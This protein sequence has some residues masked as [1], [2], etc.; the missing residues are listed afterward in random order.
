MAVTPEVSSALPARVPRTGPRHTGTESLSKGP[1]WKQ[2][3]LQPAFCLFNKLEYS[4]DDKARMIEP[5]GD[6]GLTTA[7]DAGR[8][9]Q[10]RQNRGHLLSRP[11]SGQVEIVASG[12]SGWV[13]LKSGPVDERATE[14]TA[15]VMADV[16]PDLLAVVEVESRLALKHFSDALLSAVG[17]TPLRSCH[18]D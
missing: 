15:K 1:V 13:E 4:G 18:A 5:L 10:L 6:L 11:A 14:Y 8:F 7:D 2:G 3:S 16:N 12:R 17:A 9:A